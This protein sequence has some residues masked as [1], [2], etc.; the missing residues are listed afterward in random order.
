MNLRKFLWIVAL[1]FLFFFIIQSP[2][3]AANM[4]RSLGHGIAHM[5]QQLSEFMRRVA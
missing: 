2:A 5:F 3:D 4:A 1:L